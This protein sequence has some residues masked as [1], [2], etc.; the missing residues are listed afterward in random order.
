MKRILTALAVLLPLLAF[1]DSQEARLLRFPAVG[2]DNI[3]FSYAGDLYRVGI[4]GGTAV[5]LTSHVGYEVFPRISPDG[6][7][8]A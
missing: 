8:V 2:G 3:V 1:A 4:N 5:K 6:K 7:T